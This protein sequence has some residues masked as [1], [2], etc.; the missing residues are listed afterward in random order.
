MAAKKG[1]KG[2]EGKNTG[3]KVRSAIAKKSK[4]GSTNKQIGAKV[5][6]SGSTISQIKS[7]SIK[8]PPAGLSAAINKSKPAKTKSKANRKMKK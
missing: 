7:G 4:A 1:K 3:A 2:T 8:N 6:R 5:N